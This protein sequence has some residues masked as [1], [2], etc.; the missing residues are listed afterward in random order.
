MGDGDGKVL[1][2]ISGWKLNSCGQAYKSEH[3]NRNR[4]VWDSGLPKSVHLTS[5]AHRPARWHT[6]LPLLMKRSKEESRER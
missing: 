4:L 2:P 5:T 6:L 1:F 3:A